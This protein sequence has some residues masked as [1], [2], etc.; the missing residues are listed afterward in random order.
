VAPIYQKADKVCRYDGKLVPR[1]NKLLLVTLIVHDENSELMS[2]SSD[3]DCK[4]LN[5]ARWKSE[6]MNDLA[7]DLE[8]HITPLELLTPNYLSI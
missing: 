2:P 4:D 5:A 6:M 3:S 1:E 8:G 7:T